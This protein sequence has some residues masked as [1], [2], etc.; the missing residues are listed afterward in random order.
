MTRPNLSDPAGLA[1]YRR[2]LRGVAVPWR[3]AGFVLVLA[4]TAGM[5]AYGR[6]ARSLFESVE[7]EASVGALA[8]G[9]ALLIVAMVKRTRYHKMRMAEE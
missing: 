4:G 3:A 6:G 9:W 5:I 2:E 7:G 8:A 1:A